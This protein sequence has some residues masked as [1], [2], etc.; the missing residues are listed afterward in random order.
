MMNKNRSKVSQEKKSRFAAKMT[1]VL[2]HGALNLA[3][4]IGYRLGLFDCMDA[5]ADPAPSGVI[6]TRRI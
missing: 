2:N 5:L 4:G 1:D 6:A 3:M